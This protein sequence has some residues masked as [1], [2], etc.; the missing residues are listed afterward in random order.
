MEGLYWVLIVGA[1][2]WFTGKI[3]G[4]A[5][6]GK[7]LGNYAD[8]LDIVLGTLGASIGGYLYFGAFRGEGSAPS[9]YVTA[10]LGSIILVGVAR[11]VCARY[12]P[13][14]LR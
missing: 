5:G 9:V 4:E 6:Y 7:A 10:I 11:L 3:I 12:L 8:G 14:S 13:S 2:G 1:T